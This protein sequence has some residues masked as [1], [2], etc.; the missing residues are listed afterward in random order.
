MRLVALFLLLS[1]TACAQE[2]RSSFHALAKVKSRGCTWYAAA[3]VE[4][5]PGPGFVNRFHFVLSP[6]DPGKCPLAPG[7]LEDTIRATA[8]SQ[9][10]MT[11]DVPQWGYFEVWP[12]DAA[13]RESFRRAAP[14]SEARRQRLTVR[15]SGDDGAWELLIE[16]GR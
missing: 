7:T 15:P 2:S 3:L 16:E 4:D 14:G 8:T 13:V 5:L 9:G 6:E 11:V 12:A 10:S 1:L